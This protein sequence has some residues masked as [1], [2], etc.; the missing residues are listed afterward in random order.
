[1]IEEAEQIVYRVM[2]YGWPKQRAWGWESP[3][4]RERERGREGD[5]EAEREAPTSPPPPDGL[6][7]S[8]PGRAALRRDIDHSWF[9]FLPSKT[10]TVLYQM[11]KKRKQSPEKLGGHQGTFAERVEAHEKCARD[12]MQHLPQ[13][14]WCGNKHSVITA[15]R[16]PTLLQCCRARSCGAAESLRGPPKPK[17]LAENP[18][19]CSTV[20]LNARLLQI[21]T[22]ASFIFTSKTQTT[23]LDNEYQ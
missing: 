3:S 7:L 15:V 13:G 23:G 17:C 6:C 9:P 5:R 8:Q 12:S 18:F 19:Y 14:L 21:R 2:H 22:A 11:W 16:V 10:R 20:G 1:M 4:T